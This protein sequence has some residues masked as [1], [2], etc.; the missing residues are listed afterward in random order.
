V[1]APLL[2]VALAWSAGQV[3]PPTPLELD[4]RTLPHAAEGRWKDFDPARLRPEDLPTEMTAVKRALE[5]ADFPR[6]LSELQDV[7]RQAPDFPPAWHQLGVLYFRLQRYGDGAACLERYLAVAPGRVGDT[8]V[9]GHCY[10][11]LGEF[12]KSCAHYE[13]VL[14][15]HPQEVEALRGHAL[16]L[17]RLGR[18][19]KALVELELVLALSPR[20]VEA[21]EWKA[22]ILFDE[23]KLEPALAAAGRAREIDPYS[24]RAWYLVGR[25]C[26]ELGRAGESEAA[27]R[28]FQELDAVA[29]ELRQVEGDLLYRPGDV[30]L[31]EQRAKLHARSGDRSRTR[32][33]LD[34][35]FAVAPASIEL[36][37]FALDLLEAL[38]DFDAGR[39][40]AEKLEQLGAQDARTWGRLELFYAR[41]QDRARQQKAAERQRRLS[42]K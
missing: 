23:D 32:E 17:M 26:A 13:R 19:E 24:A 36:R 30:A 25:I 29:G 27:S 31:L 20:H 16:A 10:Y 37:L 33:D 8:R 28:R 39:A 21:L 22:Q 6:A 42:G 15:V 18:T 34:Q 1:I 35:L 9:L 38:G 7:L 41:A 11:S 12:E 3:L 14:A 4:P 40:V 2:L 5:S